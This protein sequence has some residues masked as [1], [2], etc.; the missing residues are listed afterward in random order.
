[1][2]R[3]RGGIYHADITIQG[4][5]CQRS[6]GTDDKQQAQEFHDQLKAEL[7]RVAKL[8]EKPRH[9]WDEAVKLWLKKKAGKASIEDDKDKL[10]WLHK[11]L[12]GKALADINGQMI[13]T[14]LA[15]KE[16][17]GVAHA[18]V[19]RYMALIRAMFNLA[20]ANDM[21]DSI[22]NF[23]GKRRDE[24]SERVMFITKPEA[25]KLLAELPDYLKPLVRFSLAT[26]L[27]QANVTDLEWS[28]VD[29][30][31]KCAWIH[32]DQA[33]GR[34]A[35]P[36]PLN[37][38]ALAVLDLM[39]GSDDKFVFVHEGHKF[40][41]PAGKAWH[42]AVKRAGIS[43]DFRWHDLRHT[44]ATWHVM[45]GTPLEVLQRM[46]GW[47]SYGMVLRYAHFAPSFVAQYA[48]NVFQQGEVN[49]YNEDQRPRG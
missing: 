47:Q 19:N 38:E 36:V 33:K 21:I 12:S 22:P 4:K 28:Q 40:T 27:R 8:G 15:M 20:A 45:N 44:W 41:R 37:S 7:W 26:G 18:T 3:L 10:R 32:P 24:P 11:H 25:E 49:G 46:G 14:V 39:R 13:N 35:I 1:M 43:D 2:L 9:T 31:R 34:K 23:K 29:M 6:C 5:R 30:A 42:S 16:D 17:E 48:D